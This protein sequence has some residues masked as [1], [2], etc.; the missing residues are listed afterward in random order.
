LA[1]DAGGEQEVGEV[2]CA[3]KQ[4]EVLQG[5]RPSNR[6]APAS[7]AW[8]Y[9]LEVLPEVALARGLVERSDLTAMEVPEESF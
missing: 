3:G 5:Q 6:R 9:C 4:V 2:G 8:R 7:I 1:T